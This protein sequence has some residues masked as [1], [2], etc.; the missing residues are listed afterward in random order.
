MY[1]LYIIYIYEIRGSTPDM[2]LCP[3]WMEEHQREVDE[4]WLLPCALNRRKPTT[5]RARHRLTRTLQNTLF[6]L[7]LSLNFSHFI[8]LKG[9]EIPWIKNSTKTKRTLLW[10]QEN[11]RYFD[12]KIIFY[13][14]GAAKIKIN[15][16]YNFN[17]LDWII[18]GLYD[19]RKIMRWF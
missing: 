13:K 19:L 8:F 5:E 9:H 14:A 7:D 12:K 18:L 4:R 1:I 10:R 16:Y 2:I 6:V 11:C 17:R 3:K 15:R